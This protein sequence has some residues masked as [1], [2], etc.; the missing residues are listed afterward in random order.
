[1]AS[2]IRP[3]DSATSRGDGDGDGDDDG[4]RRRRRR[5]LVAATAAMA[6]GG[7]GN[8][9]DGD[10][11][12]EEGPGRPRIVF[13]GA[14]SPCGQLTTW[15]AYVTLS[16][17]RFPGAALLGTRLARPRGTHVTRSY[18]MFFR[19]RIASRSV[20]NTAGSFNIVIWEV[21]A[22]SCPGG[23]LWP[24]YRHDFANFLVPFRRAAD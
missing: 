11:D 20:D 22:V 10:S 23:R 19:C 4:E 6:T 16:F 13:S 15:W 9:G 1:M 2:P 24:T 12:F 8:G 18:G 3:V 14:V 17:G 21:V 7:D 5:R